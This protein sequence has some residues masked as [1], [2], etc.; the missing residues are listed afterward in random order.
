[1]GDAWTQEGAGTG[2]TVA[3]HIL[4]GCVSAGPGGAKE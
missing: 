3:S 4:N 1:M 2:S